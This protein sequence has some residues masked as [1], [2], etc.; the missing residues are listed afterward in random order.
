MFFNKNVALSHTCSISGDTFITG[1]SS[2]RIMDVFFKRLPTRRRSL[3]DVKMSRWA[4]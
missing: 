2:K 1:L 3:S 4:F